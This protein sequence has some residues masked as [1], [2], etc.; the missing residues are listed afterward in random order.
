MYLVGVHKNTIEEV[1]IVEKKKGCGTVVRKGNEL[2]FIPVEDN[3]C[4]LCETYESAEYNLF[5]RNNPC[6]FVPQ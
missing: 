3:N 6:C 2:W 5:L 4:F 1:T